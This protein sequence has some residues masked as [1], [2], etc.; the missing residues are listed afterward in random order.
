VLGLLAPTLV[1]LIAAVALGGSLSGLASSRVRGWPFIL[2]AFGTELVL[3]NRP[4]DAQA[5]AREAGP[6]IWLASRL[7]LL[8]VAVANAWPGR[9]Q[10]SWPWV[11]AACGVGLNSVVI[12]LNNGHMPQSEEA[13]IAVWGSSHI[14]AGRLQNVAPIDS[15]TLLP[16]LGDV[17]AE[18]AW[19]PRRNVISVGDMMLALGIGGWIFAA[20]TPSPI[21]RRRI[22]ARIGAPVHGLARHPRRC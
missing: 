3:Y 22:V 4:V 17:I 19:L 8:A 21:S 16:W 5:W 9:G 12:G 14:D 10:V 1:A 7:V 15:H 18:P 11:L 6:W 13:A 2:A 20:A